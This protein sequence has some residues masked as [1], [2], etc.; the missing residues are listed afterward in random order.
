MIL[1]GVEKKQLKS[2]SSISHYSSWLVEFIV[3]LWRIDLQSI[4]IKILS[5]LIL[6]SGIGLSQEKEKL[7]NLL[8]KAGEEYSAGW[9]HNL[10]FGKHWRDVWTTTIKVEVLDINKFAGGLIP[11][12]KGGGFQTK[13]LRFK[14]NDGH[15][16]KFRSI[17]KDP[18]KTL[19]SELRGS[20]ADDILQDQISS[21]HP[22]GAFCVAP[23]LD[24]LNILQAKP[25]LYYLPDVEEL[26]AFRSDFGNML[27]I[28]EIHP[29]VEKSE[30]VYFHEANKVEG[31]LDLFERLEKKE[32]EWVSSTE[33]LKARLVDIFLGDWDRHADQWKWARYKSSQTKE[34]WKPIPRDRDQVFAKFDGIF[35]RIAEYLVP[36]FNSFDRSYNNIEY[37]TWNGRFVDQHFLIQVTKSEWDSVTSFVYDKL[38]DELIDLSVNK[39]PPEILS[40][41]ADEIRTKLL[42]RRNNLREISD[43]YYQFINTVVDIYC[44]KDEDYVKVDRVDNEKTTVTIFKD[45]NKNELTKTVPYF[46]K[47]FD[48]NITDEIRIYLLDDDDRVKLIGSVDDGIIIRIIG[49]NGADTIIDSSNVNG[50]FLSLIPLPDAEN[51]TLVYDSG[52]KTK[53]KFGAGTLYDDE[54]ITEPDN[55]VEKYRPAQRDR[56]SQSLFFP[57]IGFSSSDGYIFGVSLNFTKYGFRAIPYK[58]N[59]SINAEYASEPNSGSLSFDT[60]FISVFRNIDLKISLNA[61]GLRFTEYYGYGNETKYNENLDEENYYRLKQKLFTVNTSLDYS[62]LK[63]L[64]LNLGLEYSYSHVKLN[65]NSLII[66]FPLNDYGIGKF[67]SV[68]GKF[69]IHFDSRDNKSFTHNGYFA[70]L[71]NSFYPKL[72][73]N[74]SNFFRSILDVRTFFTTSILSETTFAFRI[75]G[76]KVWGDFPLLSSVFLGGSDNLLGFNRERFSGDASVYGALQTRMHLTKLKLI[77]NG[78]LGFHVFAESGRVFTEYNNSN[79][80]HPSFGGGL[81]LSYLDRGF[82]IITTIAKSKEA[83]Q[84]YFGLG[85][86]I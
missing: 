51:K 34:I 72:L 5:I 7:D 2:N 69:D 86:N 61:D 17:E 80:W 40:V 18:S 28:L 66:N 35:P 77:I 23:V 19:P 38:T 31:T 64:K 53:I 60:K 45:I 47:T 55:Q 48:N 59:F 83:Y 41:S 39:L 52:K 16:W 71:S 20:I 1:K 32:D 37:L 46:R 4:L 25:Y 12:K 43:E 54:K 67:A 15:Y 82:N 14:G 24:S 76:E 70:F 13:S 84:I 49:G 65:N 85:F 81:W 68:N 74:K 50:Y 21:S 79:I 8:V 22:Y 11:I 75:H 58:S 29:D 42:E 36:Q 10:F 63:N 44:G 73:D 30:N 78:N 62:L 56:S 27:G 9:L 57:I 33:Y 26:G 6:L 3:C